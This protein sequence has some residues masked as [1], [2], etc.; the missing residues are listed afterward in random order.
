MTLARLS[1]R[2]LEYIVAVAD[3]GHFSRAAERCAV[4]QPALSEQIHKVE[5]MLG[6]ALFERS[7]RGVLITPAG[8]P[9]VAQARRTIAEGRR[10]VELSRTVAGELSGELRLWSIATLGPYLVPHL[11][12]PIREWFPCAKLV[13]GEGLT[14]HIVEQLCAGDIDVAFISLPITREELEID[15]LFFEPFVVVFPRGH[16]IGQRVPVDPDALDSRDLLLLDEGHCLRDQ[17]LALCHAKPTMAHHAA[18]LETVRHLVAAGAGYSILPSLAASDGR[19]FDGLIDYAR[20]SDPSV[21]RSIAL[22]WRR[23]DPRDGHFRRL[24]SLVRDDRAIKA[25]LSKIGVRPTEGLAAI[26]GPGRA[27]ECGTRRRRP[28]R[29]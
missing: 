24:A 17:V 7:R 29:W 3:L 16:A 1:L 18:H 21:G 2:D 8:G 22:V 26:S 23:T 11:V 15:V 25:E 13:I 12:R 27:R 14:E 19:T 10:L 4:S 9:I 6:L 28:A 5:E 20:F